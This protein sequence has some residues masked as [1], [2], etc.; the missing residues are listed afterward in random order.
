MYKTCW[1]QDVD[2]ILALWTH[3]ATTIYEYIWLKIL[4]EINIFMILGFH[5]AELH[6][7]VRVVRI[8]LF[9]VL[10]YS[11][12]LLEHY[13]QKSLSPRPYSHFL[14]YEHIEKVVYNVVFGMLHLERLRQ[15]RVGGL[16][17][18]ENGFWPCAVSVQKHSLANNFRRHF[19]IEGVVLPSPLQLRVVLFCVS[20]QWVKFTRVCVSFGLRGSRLYGHPKP[21]TAYTS[22][23]YYLWGSF[24]PLPLLP[25]CELRVSLCRRTASRIDDNVFKLKHT[26]RERW[27]GF[28]AAVEIWFRTWLLVIP[29]AN[30]KCII[31]MMENRM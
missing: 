19:G 17:F 23:Y 24:Q 9:K 15:R 12:C 26:L 13:N 21:Q 18:W 10:Q 11:S 30:E 28:V 22:F 4:F 1:G 6:T 16:S 14:T 25:I 31:T 27:G 7:F 2:P 5:V 29:E 3:I 8:A 20:L